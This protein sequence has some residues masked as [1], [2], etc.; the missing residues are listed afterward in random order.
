MLNIGLLL[1]FLAMKRNITILIIIFTL[2]FHAQSFSQQNLTHWINHVS[3]PDV[4]FGE[5]VSTDTDGN[6]YITGFFKTQLAINEDT[7]QVGST[8]NSLF[9]S[10]ISP[11]NQTLWT[12]TAQADGLQGVNG[13]KSVYKDGFI[14]LLGDFRGET[15]FGS[16]DFSEITLNAEYRSFFI[17]KYTDNGVLEWVKPITTSNATGFVTVGGTHGLAVDDYGNVYMSTGFRN[18]ANIAGMEVK[19]PTPFENLGNALVFKLDA[20]GAYQW[21]WNSALGGTENA[22][23]INV[24]QQDELYF[25]VRYTDTLNINGNISARPGQGGFALVEFDLQGNY[26]SHLFMETE[27]DLITGV[28]C[29]D[30]EFDAQQD[31]YLAGSYRTDILIGPGA[32]LLTENPVRSDGFIIKINGDTHEWEWGKNY[33][34]PEENDEIK[35]LIYTEDDNFML[36]GNFRGTMQFNEDISLTSLEE[37]TDGFWAA[38]DTEGNILQAMNYGSNTND[39]VGQMAVSPQMHTYVIGRFQDVFNYDET[40]FNSW[41]SFDVFLI[42]LRQP[43]SNANLQSVSFNNEPFSDF[44][45]ETLQYLVSLPHATTEVPETDATPASSFAEVLISQAT[46]LTGSEEDRTASVVVTSEDES[47]Q[48][49]YAFTFRLMNNDT[50]LVNIFLDGNE[51][52]NFDSQTFEYEYIVPY[53][54]EFPEV[55]ALASDENATVTVSE[56]QSPEPGGYWGK[57]EISVVS[58]DTEYSALYTIH[59]RKQHTNALLQEILI[60]GDVFENFDPEVFNYQIDHVPTDNQNPIVE[61]TTQSPFA[62]HMIDQVTDINGEEEQRTATISVTAEAPSF[63]EQYNL[64]FSLGTQIHNFSKQQKFAVYP[65]PASKNL[66]LTFKEIPV[67]VRLSDTKGQ[68]LMK[69][70]PVSQQ[71]I[72]PVSHLQNGVYFISV[73][74]DKGSETRSFIKQ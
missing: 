65:N 57:T 39:A 23:A 27:A 5:G 60:D 40:T 15:V 1:N 4:L 68:L 12:V 7:L 63:F 38:A 31:I 70:E 18:S 48:R 55:T 52:E 51:L 64:V 26:Q 44:N 25:T 35:S 28:R 33:G 56:F 66:K 54:E 3:A 69:A 30:L 2:I 73:I 67:E 62:S 58:E 29:F 10:K 17:A 72:L 32:F 37:S 13:F 22:M 49:E 9:F 24:N 6:A 19:D 61:A 71:K 47:N 42:K 41:G 53:D 45:P 34:D 14:Y 46:S 8:R 11:D 16:V 50:T 43:S 74:F 21:H 59:M 36:A 20:N